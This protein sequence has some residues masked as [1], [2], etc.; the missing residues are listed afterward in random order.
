M[1]LDD[2]VVTEEE[3][4]VFTNNI[5]LFKKRTTPMGKEIYG[6]TIKDLKRKKFINTFPGII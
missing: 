3:K 2:D 4:N 1:I 6:P 5:V